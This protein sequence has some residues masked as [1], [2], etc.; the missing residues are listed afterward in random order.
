VWQY[1][2]D[3][4]FY[5]DPIAQTFYTDNAP[6]GLFA[7]SIDVYFRTKGTSPVTLELRD[8]V[9]GYPGNNV[10]PFSNV[11]LNA[12][13]VSVSTEDANGVVTF[14]K[15]TF[16]FSSPVYLSSATEYCFVVMPAGNDPGY[17]LWVSELGENEVGS[18]TRISKQ[19]HV[20]VLF[21]SANAR[22]W[23]AEQAEDIKFSL[24]RARFQTNI[25]ANAIFD[26]QPVDF[27]K[28]SNKTFNTFRFGSGDRLH[29]FTFNITNGGSGYGSAPTVTVTGGGSAA[30]G[31]A[32]TANLT[33]GRY[34]YDL[35]MTSGSNIKTRVVEGIVTVLPSVTR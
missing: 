27:L 20:G 22:T 1:F 33:A 35:V 18:T 34:F 26:N 10:I 28:F 29:S 30:T 14:Q 21:H 4:N 32:I 7:T 15:T 5:I 6:F 9:N 13:D 12:S 24:Y 16:T 17:E 23:T 25:T 19:P 3:I 11:T 2:P 8:T 31:L